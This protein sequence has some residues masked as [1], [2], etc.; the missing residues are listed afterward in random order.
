M[1][2]KRKKL[3]QNRTKNV[4]RNLLIVDGFSFFAY[5]WSHVFG[6]LQHLPAWQ[7]YGGY[8]LL[9]G[10]G[11]VFY[12]VMKSMPDYYAEEVPVR[13]FPT[14]DTTVEVVAE[15]TENPPVEAA[16]NAAQT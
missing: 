11:V 8:G 7:L 16:D 1:V 13:I 4:Y 15:D 3:K 9:L 12:L 6:W 10:L 14:V 2:E 5:F